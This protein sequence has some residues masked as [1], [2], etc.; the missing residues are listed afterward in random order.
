MIEIA[1]DGTFNKFQIKVYNAQGD[2]YPVS[3]NKFAWHPKSGAIK[4]SN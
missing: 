1:P 4:L 2:T 3:S